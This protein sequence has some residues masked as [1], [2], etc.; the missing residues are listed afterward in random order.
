[1]LDHDTDTF[2]MADV[3]AYQ[4]RRIPEVMTAPVRN[5]EYRIRVWQP[6]QQAP[7]D[8]VPPPLVL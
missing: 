7:E 8:A 5:L 6:T 3:A 1:M 4:P 2:P